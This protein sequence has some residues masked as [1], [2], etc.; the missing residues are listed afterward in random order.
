MEV[1]AHTFF[2]T[3]FNLEV[4]TPDFHCMCSI[5]DV[6]FWR[7]RPLT[8]LGVEL[9]FLSR[10]SRSLATVLTKLLL[11]PLILSSVCIVGL[12][13]KTLIYSVRQMVRF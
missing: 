1:K 7:R 9:R 13:Q 3:S 12:T 2:A 4:S 6:D 5:D 11:S 10:P 8:L